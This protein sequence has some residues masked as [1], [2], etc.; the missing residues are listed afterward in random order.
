MLNRRIESL[1]LDMTNFASELEATFVID[2]I[3]MTGHGQETHGRRGVPTSD[4]ATTH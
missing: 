3:E 4:V 1:T 2:Y